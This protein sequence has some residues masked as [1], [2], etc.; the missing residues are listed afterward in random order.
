M[1][2]LKGKISGPIQKPAGR[3]SVPMGWDRSD[4]S[5]LLKGMCEGPSES[6]APNSLKESGRLKNLP[7]KPGTSLLVQGTKEAPRHRPGVPD[8]MTVARPV[9]L[10][11]F[12]KE[13]FQFDLCPTF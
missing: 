8:P 2:R 11:T 10:L 12:A 3:V 9:L 7:R 5:G 6:L 13:R 4:Q 1:D